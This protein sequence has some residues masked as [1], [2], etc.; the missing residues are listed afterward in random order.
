MQSD[1]V[2]ADE[3]MCRL[4]CSLGKAYKVIKQLNS[5]LN[6]KGYITISGRVS[7]SYFEQKCWL[8]ENDK[9]SESRR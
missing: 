1:V 5:E 8:C 2:R 9:L 6:K 3:V 7:R 4:D